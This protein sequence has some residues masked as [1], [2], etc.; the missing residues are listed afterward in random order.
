[1]ADDELKI[2]WPE[3]NTV[4]TE[5]RRIGQPAVAD[6]LVEA[7]RSGTTSSGIIGDIGLVL[8]DHGLLRSQLDAPAIVAW[9]AIMADVSRAFRG[10]KFAQWL[11]RLTNY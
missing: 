6:K 10:S 1:M 5:L 7:A 9:D 8:R 2:Q 4:V 11:A 3:L